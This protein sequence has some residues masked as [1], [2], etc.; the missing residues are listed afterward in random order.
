M[1]DFLSKTITTRK[2][3]RWRKCVWTAKQSFEG[4][5]N[6]FNGYESQV[7]AI[8]IT[9]PCEAIEEINSGITENVNEYNSIL[10]NVFKERY[11]KIDDI[12]ADCIMS[13]Y[14]H[15]N[16]RGHKWM[17]KRIKKYLSDEN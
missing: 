6:S 11:I 14:Y 9:P 3:R 13:D 12:P 4:Y 8:G 16:A 15:L 2:L 1:R 5:C 17:Y 10:K 7:Y